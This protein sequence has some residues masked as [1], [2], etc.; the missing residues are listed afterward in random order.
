MKFALISSTL[1]C[2]LVLFSCE[3]HKR[4]RMDSEPR[5][6]FEIQYDKN[7]PRRD[8]QESP[9]EGTPEEGKPDRTIKEKRARIAIDTLRA[10]TA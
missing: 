8:P 3:D 5:N 10:M 7:R 9:S 6:T 2:C 4:D 1:L